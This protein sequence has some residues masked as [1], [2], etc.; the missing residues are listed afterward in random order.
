MSLQPLG[1]GASSPLPGYLAYDSVRGL[2]LP[3]PPRKSP[4]AD[5]DKFI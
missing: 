5:F 4:F 2:E 1:E 3:L